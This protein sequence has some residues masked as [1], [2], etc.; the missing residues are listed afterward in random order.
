MKIKEILIVEGK[1]DSH[2]LKCF[3]DCDT[4][5]THG[6]ALSEKTLE[7]IE[8]ANK[9][10]GVIIFTDPDYPGERIRKLINQR[11][12]GCKNAFI[13]KRKARTSK[14]VGVEHAS[15]ED[16]EEALNHLM[17]YTNE[18]KE[19]ISWAEFLELGL[20]GR[21][22]STKRRSILEDYLHLGKSNAKT[23][24]KRLNMIQVNQEECYR[25]LEGKE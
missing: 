7:M 15:R 23:L 4:I 18:V 6:S 20:S 1:N 12:P 8:L 5:E 25:I 14:K 19:T 17:T 3:F 10:R 21:E 13:D 16:L 2:R 11:I 24:F 22:D 9:K